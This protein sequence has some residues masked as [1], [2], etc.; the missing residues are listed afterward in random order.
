MYLTLDLLYNKHNPLFKIVVDGS[1]LKKNN[2]TC[3]KKLVKDI[4]FTELL[5]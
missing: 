5:Q 3:E 1:I 2:I 4:I